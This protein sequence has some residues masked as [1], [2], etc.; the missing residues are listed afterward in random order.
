MNSNDSDVLQQAHVPREVQALLGALQITRASTSLLQTLSDEEWLSL[1]NF[2]DLAHLTL[3]LATLPTSGFPAW[4]VSRLET[5]RADNFKRFERVKATYVEARNALEQAGVEHIVVKG[6]AQFPMYVEH[7]RLRSQSDIDLYCPAH[8]IDAAYSALRAI[9]YQPSTNVDYRDADHLPAMVRLGEWQWRGNAFDPEMP[10]SIE[11]HFC[12][13]NENVSL[14][15]V[16]GVD[17]FWERRTTR[18]IDGVSFPC[19]NSVD[20]LGYFSLHILRNILSREWVVNHVLELATFLESK[21]E[22]DSFWA[23]WL[24]LHDAPLRQYEAIAFHYARVWFGCRLHPTADNQVQSLPPAQSS[25]LHHFAGAAMELMFTPNKDSFWLHMDL[26][27]SVG[28]WLTLV[29]RL[30]MPNR[31]SRM[32]GPAVTIRNRRQTESDHTHAVTQYLQYL[33]SRTTSYFRLSLV[34]LARGLRWRL[35]HH[36]FAREFW[37]FLVASFFLTWACQYTSFSSTCS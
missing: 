14:F 32:G 2:C 5:N 9:N 22:D 16:P 27:N 11:L 10:L 13:W 4:V 33:A 30:F 29:K 20:H 12:L 7:P 1:L 34:T 19:L 15:P 6:F 28:A 36:R 35:G 23:D 26:A 24:G 21:A 18:T 37:I 3:K 8:M 31:I 25:F 17:A